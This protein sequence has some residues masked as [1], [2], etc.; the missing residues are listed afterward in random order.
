LDVNLHFFLGQEVAAVHEQAL[1][2]AALP[3]IEDVM[4]FDFAGAR[5]LNV[6]Q[7][8]RQAVFGYEGV[9]SCGT[10]SCDVVISPV[11]DDYTVLHELSHLW[12]SVFRERWLSEG[13]AQLVPE[14]VAPLLPEGTL[15]GEPVTRT[16]STYPLQLDEWSE[17]LTSVI[18]AEETQ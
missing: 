13:F 8:G 18:G 2:T 9:T 14:E 1:I 10:P 11:A 16:Q 5:T 7:G 15:I 12:S 17:D 3:V 4:G 6:S